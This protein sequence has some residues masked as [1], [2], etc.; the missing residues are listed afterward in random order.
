MVFHVTAQRGEGGTVGGNQQP[1]VC[2]CV[3]D[4]PIW[5][6]GHCCGLLSLGVACLP[7]A[8]VS[9]DG[10]LGLCWGSQ[11]SASSADTQ[12]QSFHAMVASRTQLLVVIEKA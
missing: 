8:Q 1:A 2:R 10:K 9:A 5:M 11:S 7:L 12:N 4:Q 6:Q 3:V